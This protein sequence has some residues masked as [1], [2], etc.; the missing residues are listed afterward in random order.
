MTKMR[1]FIYIFGLSTALLLGDAVCN[2]VY[3]QVYVER[4]GKVS[5]IGGKLFYIHKV[6]RGQT[7]YSISRAYMV[8]EE[9][10]LEA[11]NFRKNYKIKIRED[12]YVPVNPELIK[13]SEKLNKKSTTNS[14]D[15]I[16]MVRSTIV[17]LGNSPKQAEYK[18]D[19]DST[20]NEGF[21]IVTLPG[22]S[23]GFNLTKGDKNQVSDQRIN[24][25]KGRVSGLFMLPMVGS[26]I[27]DRNS[28]DLYRGALLAVEDLKSQ[29][30]DAS[31]EIEGNGNIGSASY[32]VAVGD[33]FE[34]GKRMAENLRI[35]VVAPLVNVNYGSGYEVQFAP[36]NGGKYEK[37]RTELNDPNSN[38]VLI[39][40]DTYCDTVA[41]NEMMTVMPFGV[42]KINYNRYVKPSELTN[43]L[44]KDKN[45][46][47]VIPINHQG[48]IEDVLSKITTI[49]SLKKEY[50]I[51]VIG[52]NRWK[53]LPNINPE[54][55][56]KA[57][58]SY[59]T[60]YHSDRSN[61]NMARFYNNY[62]NKYGELPNA[63]SMRG[64]DVVMVMSS[65]IG[66]WGSEGLINL[67]TETFT[68]LQTSYRFFNGMG[69]VYNSDWVVVTMTPDFKIITR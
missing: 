44:S 15:Q 43:Y 17:P 50:N 69:K 31:V 26:A 24:A 29:G 12:I 55:L 46:I 20:E 2:D 5:N 40:H 22:D 1:R 61:D 65:A 36:D 7:L 11:N 34:N 58:V 4:S 35:P 42:T 66:Q 39:Q 54:Q 48:S 13:A 3:A 27:A 63:F 25:T 33:L 64:Y 62:I 68:P 6:E 28:N 21:E 57:N 38:V 10:I 45:N 23:S 30:V 37:F 16:E 53:N 67:P 41:L 8:T 32:I 14:V 47:I 59:P 56:F 9:D 52:T 49:N 19:I 51:N 18:R 60:S